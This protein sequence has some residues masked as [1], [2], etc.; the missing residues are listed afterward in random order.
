M[1]TVLRESLISLLHPVK[2]LL[3]TDLERK[4]ISFTSK[5]RLKKNIPKFLRWTLPV[6]TD[7]TCIHMLYYCFAILEN[8]FAQLVVY[9]RCISILEGLNRF[10]KNNVQSVSSLV[11]GNW[12]YIEIMRLFTAVFSDSEKLNAQY[13][14]NF[15][16]S[17]LPIKKS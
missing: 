8:D 9:Y 15:P 12:Q 4:T 17:V 5:V 2:L 13:F 14:W 16:P 7:V 1:W 10:Y 3:Q 6:R 11:V